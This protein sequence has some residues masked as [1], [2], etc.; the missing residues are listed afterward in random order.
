MARP[1]SYKKA[2][3]EWP[4]YTLVLP[5]A[6]FILLFAYWPAGSAVY[7][8]FFD[9]SGDDSKRFI[10][11]ENF[12]RVLADSVFWQ[13]FVTIG[14]LV[15]ANIVKLIPSIALAVMI[16]RLYSARSQYL[17]RVMVVLPMVVPMLVVL[18]VWRFFLDPNIGVLNDLLNAT[19]FKGVL[20]WLD[21]LF[22]W[23]L[24]SAER[25]IGWLS[26]PQLIVPSLI[27][28]GFPWISSIGVLLYLAG[29]QAIGSEVYEA[30][31]IDGAGSWRQLIHIELPLI[32]TQIRLT[33][34]LLIIGTLQSFGLQ[35]VLLDENGGPGGAGMV[36]GLWMYNR[37]FANSEF[38]YAC[39]LGL[40]LFVAILLLTYVNN[41]MVRS[42]K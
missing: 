38:G 8:S 16:H 25:P 36:P 33:L 20:I 41:R 17:Y 37:A 7:H 40:F 32:L 9:W 2:L 4:L 14:I 35:L 28:W 5:A 3:H 24:F 29:L 13:S 15:L 6:A 27:L 26:Q 1:I 30:A 12:Q 10:G 23:G 19:G 22:G 18:L 31:R 42:D 11:L 39:A 34:V 21:G